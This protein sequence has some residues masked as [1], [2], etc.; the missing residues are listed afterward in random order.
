MT[1][2]TASSTSTDP[3]FD[4]RDKVVLITGGSRGLGLQMAHGFAARGAN[5]II[6]SRKLA[7]CEEVAAD[8]RATYGVEAGAQACNVSDWSQCDELMDKVHN[9]FGQLDVLVNNAGLSPLYPS[10]DK[11]EEALFDK[12]IGVNLR[13]PFRLSVLAGTAMAEG[14][15]GSIINITS[16]QSIKPRPHALPY[17]AAKAGLNAVT[18]GLAHAF[19]PTVRVNAILCGPFLTEVSEAW[20]MEEFEE[21]AQRTMALQRGGRP[22]EIVGAALY[23]A[24]DA[25]SFATGAVLRLDGGYV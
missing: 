23:Y 25:S 22:G 6:A 15:G 8:L 16:T 3:L 10:L 19:G 20:D 14:R 5:V 9:E 24:S 17:A 18:E 4:V 7:A 2:P 12:V 11:V 1:T 13:G 21:R